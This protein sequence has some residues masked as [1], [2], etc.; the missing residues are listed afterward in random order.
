MCK[1]KSLLSFKPFLA[2]LILFLFFEITN[3]FSQSSE[4]DWILYRNGVYNFQISY[5]NNWNV[6]DALIPPSEFGLRFIAQYNE[7]SY[8]INEMVTLDIFK[9]DQIYPDVDA[10]T[11]SIINSK[12]F[13]EY[14]KLITFDDVDINGIPAKKIE[15]I[16][17]EYYIPLKMLNYVMLIDRNVFVFTY[18]EDFE[19]YPKFLNTIEKIVKS[20]KHN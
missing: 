14:A 4:K 11:K 10:Y 5:P 7:S 3:I 19:I 2:I 12:T 18:G 6:I 17:D 8:N 20:F 13:N 15:Y 16:N 9:E 1:I